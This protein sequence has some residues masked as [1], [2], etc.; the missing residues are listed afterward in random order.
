MS[1]YL[2]LKVKEVIHETADA[3]TIVFHNPDGNKVFYKSGQFLTFILSVDGHEHRRSYSLSSSPFVDQEMA[4]T[5]KKVAGGK[6][7]NYLV[8]HAK[9]G[10]G[11]KIMLPMGNFTPE[12]QMDRKRN[13]VLI[14]G[15]SG[16]TPL[17]SIAKSAL[18]KEPKT[19]VILIYANRDEDSII[20]RQAIANLS[21]KYP[22]NFKCIHILEAPSSNWQG[23][24]GLIHADFLKNVLEEVVGLEMTSNSE[25][26]IC[27]P[28]GMMDVAVHALKS[29]SIDVERIHKESFVAAP[30]QDPKPHAAPDADSV[31]VTVKYRK[32]EYKIPVKKGDYILQTALDMDIDLPYSCQ[33]GICTACMGKC[34]AGKVEMDDN[35]ALTPNEVKKGLILTCVGKPASEGVIIEID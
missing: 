27:G 16:I 13:L 26:Y 15:G 3:A 10:D 4:V 25:Y 17:I 31:E 1:D 22:D 35:D 6:V 7:S 14:G 2:T 30:Q 11:F 21:N 19:Q 12:Y 20:F 9:P 23:F 33:S 34:V 24:T 32:R 8:D 29:F 18:I 5:I 28:N